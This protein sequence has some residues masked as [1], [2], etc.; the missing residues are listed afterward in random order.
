ML[1]GHARTGSDVQG[2]ARGPDYTEI[3]VEPALMSRAVP[4]NVRMVAPDLGTVSGARASRRWCMNPLAF[5]QT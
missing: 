3:V 2:G 1:Q 4:W 5:A